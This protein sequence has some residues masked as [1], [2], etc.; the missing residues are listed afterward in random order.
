MKLITIVYHWS[1]GGQ[2]ET[3]LDGHLTKEQISLEMNKQENGNLPYSRC[4]GWY[5]WSY[6]KIKS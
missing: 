5:G 6:R 1:D 4:S 3:F 2:A